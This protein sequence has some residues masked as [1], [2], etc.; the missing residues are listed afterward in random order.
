MS[1]QTPNQ[2]PKIRRRDSKSSAQQLAANSTRA[3]LIEAA[4]EV[5]A[6]I[7]YEAATVREICARAGANVAAVNYHFGD[8]LGLYTELLRSMNAAPTGAIRKVLNSDGAPEEVLRQAIKV[9]LENICGNDQPELRFRLMMH[10]LAHPTPALPRVIDEAVRP[11]YNRLRELIGAILGVPWDHPQTR[12]CAVSIVGQILHYKHGRP[13]LSRLWPELKMKPQQMEQIANHIAEFSLA[14]LKAA[15]LGAGMVRAGAEAEPRT[16]RESTERQKEND[17]R[18]RN[19]QAS[20]GI[21]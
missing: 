11:I 4:G 21:N 3:K 7:G 16:E 19:R 18:T 15:D 6:Q 1:N 14:Y 12:L 20:S 13:I 5:F 8:K 9:M 10:E 2:T 17:D